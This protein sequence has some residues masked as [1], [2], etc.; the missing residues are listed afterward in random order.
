MAQTRAEKA[1]NA[2]SRSYVAGGNVH[3]AYYKH[4][5]KYGDY[6]DL[7]IYKDVKITF[8]GNTNPKP[9]SQKGERRHDSLS[10]AKVKLFRLIVAN[11]KRHGNFR[12]IFATYT[13][14]DEVTDLSDALVG[15]RAYLSRLAHHLGYN[16]KYVAVPQ[17]QWER[18]QKSGVKVWHFHFCFFNVPKL[19]FKFNDDAWG[20]GTV[21][22]QF[23]RGVRSIGAYLAGYFNKN[24]WAEIP[25]NRKFY[26]S[27]H[28]LI[29]PQDVFNSQD[30]DELLGTGRVSILSTFEGHTYSQTKYKLNQSK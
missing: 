14:K 17:I 12:P 16:P 29:R 15:M 1:K 26:Y 21:N 6:C 22:L 13:F 8:K 27:S 7:R 11:T 9:K 20:L 23:V 4:A 25:L 30:I 3:K 24:D 10:R 28:G 2:I 5:I 19:D 18:Y